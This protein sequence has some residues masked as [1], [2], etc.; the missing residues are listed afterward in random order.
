[1]LRPVRLTLRFLRANR[2]F[3]VLLVLF[4]VSLVFAFSSGFWLVSRLSYLLLFA[5]PVALAWGWINVRALSAEVTRESDRIPWGQ[6][7][8]ERFAVGNLGFLPK[9]WLD[10]SDPSDLPGYQARR[11]ITLGGRRRR[12]W[13]TTVECRHR[14][15]YTRGPLTIASGDPFGIF[16][17][18]RRFGRSQS[19]LVYPRLV[20]LPHFSAPPAN[21]PGDGRFRRRTHFVTPN[22]AGVRDYAWGD[23]FNRI[24][25]RSTA[26]T[27]KLMVKTFELDPVSDI[28]LILDLERRVHVGRG[29][30]GTE[31]SA[32]TAAASIANHYLNVNRNVGLL[33]F[34][35]RLTMIEPERGGQQLT[36]I[37]E[38][39]AVAKAAGDVPLVNLITEEGKRF[40][41]QTTV[42]VV[43]PS[44]EES[45]VVGLQSL[46]Q[47]GVRSAA[48]LLEPSTFGSKESALMTYGLLLA[49]DLTT[50]LV[51]RGDNLTEAMAPPEEG[52]LAV[53]RP[54][55]IGR[56]REARAE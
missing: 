2:N 30:D 9:L 49:N 32:V 27:G 40:G 48:V 13:E 6:T 5:V 29:D 31:E 26:R 55:S 42:V 18:V 22:A 38:T 25:W 15:S 36:R 28:W 1:M 20:E 45:W 53:Q 21:L 8:R 54:G 14:G 39:L 52:P 16:R 35:E 12:S 4:A 56:G 11:V 43:T 23:S 41:R 3:T 17:F 10:V 44:A 50:Y 51:R 33:C 47:R 7:L 24:H 34:G 37:L 46:V 19:L